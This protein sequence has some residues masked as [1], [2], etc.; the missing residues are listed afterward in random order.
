MDVV[1]QGLPKPNCPPRVTCGYTSRTKHSKR[2]RCRF[3]RPE[4]TCARVQQHME[5]GR[6]EPFGKLCP[7]QTGQTCLQ[8]RDR[9]SRVNH[10]IKSFGAHEAPAA[11]A[12]AAAVTPLALAVPPTAAEVVDAPAPAEAPV[13]PPPQPQYSKGP[14]SNEGCRQHERQT[15]LDLYRYLSSPLAIPPLRSHQFTNMNMFPNHY[16]PLVITPSR[17][18]LSYAVLYHRVT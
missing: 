7:Q 12:A 3:G 4:H 9:L 17:L 16:H 13:A 11:R 5:G 2:V 10:R 8:S 18:G 6:P 15:L 1:L 14:R